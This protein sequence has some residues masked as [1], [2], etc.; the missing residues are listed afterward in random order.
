M[1]APAN[2]DFLPSK[3]HL[4]ALGIG[5]QTSY[6]EFQGAENDF[7]GAF[8]DFRGAKN[9][10]QSAKN[11]FEG[12]END[13]QGAMR[14]PPPYKA[15]DSCRELRSRVVGMGCMQLISLYSNIVS[16][17]ELITY[18]PSLDCN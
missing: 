12:A 17:E 4:E 5:I 18:T 10:F 7:Q 8:N 9:E 14:P 16:K 11:E 13:F 3:I 15:E 1:D 2:R 6:S